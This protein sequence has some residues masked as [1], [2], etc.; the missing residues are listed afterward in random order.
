MAYESLSP[1]LRGIVD[2]LSAIQGRELPL[3]G[4]FA[5][6]AGVDRSVSEKTQRIENERANLEPPVV[7]PAVRVHPETNR[8][9]LFLG[10]R[11]QRFVGMTAEESRPL[12]DFLNDRSF[13]YEFVYRHR[14]S[15][16]D[17]VMWDNRCTMHVALSDYDVQRDSR[18]MFRCAVAGTTSG[19]VYAPELEL[20]RA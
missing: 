7:H 5:G 14:W 9:S 4:M 13:A 18:H 19:Q 2:G 15:V 20:S 8:R 1:T 16:G 12:L 11:A 6:T 17:L 10:P 3:R